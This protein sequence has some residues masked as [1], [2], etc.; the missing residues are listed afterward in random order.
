MLNPLRGPWHDLDVVGAWHGELRDAAG[1]ARSPSTQAGA[2]GSIPGLV[3]PF[4]A[5]CE[6]WFVPLVYTNSHPASAVPSHVYTV[7]VFVFCIAG[8]RGGAPCLF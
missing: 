6:R 3:Y 5:A 4:L 7:F 2:L 8:N 1:P